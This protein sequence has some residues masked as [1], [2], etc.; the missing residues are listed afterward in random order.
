VIC[1]LI[2][3]TVLVIEV[4][5]DVSAQV[6]EE[7]VARY[8]GPENDSDSAYAMA[9]DL[10]GNIYITG[11][12]CSKTA[13]QQDITTIAYDTS[14][15]ELWAVSYNGPGNGWDIAYTIT[16]DS[17]G[18]IYVAGESVGIGSE[19]DIVTIKYD[20]M[21]N[22]LWVARYNGPGNGRDQATSSGI[23]SSGNI[24][25][26]GR[27]EGIVTKHDYVTIKYDKDGNELWVARY[28]GPGNRE[29][30]L[31]SLA[32]DAIGNVFVTGNSGGM[33]TGIDYATIKYDTFGN[34]LW[35]ARYNGLGNGADWARAIEVDTLSGNVYVTGW[36]DSVDTSRD[37]ATIAYDTDG[38]KLWI[39]L[40]NGDSNSHDYP[41]DLAISTSGNIYVTG[42][43]YRSGASYDYA[44]VAY[45]IHGNQLWVAFYDGL[46]HDWDEAHLIALSSSGNIYVT[47]YEKSTGTGLDYATIAYDSDG[48]Q[49]WVAT[50]NGPG[51][52]FDR[53]YAL[54]VD[55]FE[56]VFVTGVSFGSGTDRDYATLKYSRQDQIPVA[57]IDIDPNTLNLKSKGR[58]ITCHI[59]LP[60]YDVNEID[61]STILLEDTLP[62]EWGDIQGDTLMVKFDRSEVEDML[63]PG[64]YNL[65]VTGELLDGT[66]LEGYSDEVR[67][68]DPGK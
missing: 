47:G 58:W 49:L 5:K 65:K 64:T 8:N 68:I 59:D 20:S 51:N 35:V 23:D 18:Y 39:A 2:I 42:Q 66:G 37:Y 4:P 43:S 25:I 32:I 45:D 24:Y 30:D 12:I 1:A 29:E 41:D 16:V 28:N 33:G 63:V 62:A 34:E 26:A 36:C 13:H 53:P 7:W 11:V 17:S 60:G 67:V 27:S 22:E 15:N 21:G 19:E 57:K 61:I 40:F 50:Y 31:S 38:N 54:V 52:S 14:G 56:N 10:S 55:P 48:N 6:T 44:T 46:A 3:V 9:I